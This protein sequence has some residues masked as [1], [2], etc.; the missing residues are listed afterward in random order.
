MSCQRRRRG[1]LAASGLL[2]VTL[3][4][5][6]GAALAT[7][8]DPLD[9]DVDAAQQAEA[10][11][12]RR[13]AEAERRLD[14]ISRDLE[15]ASQALEAASEN[16]T[17]ALAALDQ[18]AAEAADA[19]EAVN[20]ATEAGAAARELLAQS[21]RSRARGGAPNALSVVTQAESLSDVV[22]E[23]AIRRAVDRRLSASVD[24]AAIARAEANNAGARWEAALVALETARTA[25]E[26]ALAGAEASFVALQ[27]L[28]ANSVAERDALFR[29]LAALRNTTV[30]A[31]RARQDARDAAAQQ[32]AEN[33][34]RDQA[35][36]SAP[37]PTPTP[38]PTPTPTPSPDPTATPTPSP[39]PTPTPSPTPT[40]P[41][42]N[43]PPAGGT[44]RGTAQQGI[45]AVEWARAQIGTP[46]QWGGTGNPG[47]DC[48]GLTQR[49]WA[50]QGIDI[51]RTSRSQWNA[52]AKIPFESLRPG[53]LLFWANDISDPNT[54]RHVAIFSGGGNMIEARIPG[55][56]VHETPIR[57]IGGIMPWAG[58][59]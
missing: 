19:Y 4:V 55:T 42:G 51:T 5:G 43:Q 49:A 22:A 40:A 10:Q 14:Q 41:P 38:S 7:P 1:T 21:A 32:Q 53:D 56:L 13:V 48:S 59:P 15:A 23:D 27:T 17:E 31:E 46:Y 35:G 50:S 44:S 8:N 47:F 39:T 36:G 30:E 3:T 33:D 16:Y 29:E 25:A 37:E 9:D 34:A 11:G 6:G 18:A 20:A 52:V 12:A 28:Q 26:D 24:A 54:I 2:A 45:G 58:R 57:W